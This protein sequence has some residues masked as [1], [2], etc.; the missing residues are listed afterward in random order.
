M[1]K[2]QQAI[3]AKGVKNVRLIK[4]DGVVYQLRKVR[5]ADEYGLKN[6]AATEIILHAEGKAKKVFY[7]FLEKQVENGEFIIG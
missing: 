6:G 3:N 4:K 2:L 1:S 7:S 5:A